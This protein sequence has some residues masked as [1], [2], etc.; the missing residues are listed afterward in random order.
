MARED[1]S[2]SLRR[3]A[4]SGKRPQTTAGAVGSMARLSALAGVAVAAILIPATAFVA[5]TGNNVTNDLV[6]LPLTLEDRPNPQ[7]TRLLA[8]NGEL[9]AYFYKENRQDVPLKEIAPVMQEAMLAIEDARFF[10]HGALDLKGTIRAAVNNASEGQTQGGSTITQ[11][12]VKLTL[13][14]QA[15]TKAERIAATES[16]LARKARELKL[17]I[18]YEREHTKKEILERYLNIA[19]F[20]D[21]AYGIQAAA[22]HY[23]SQSPD[24]LTAT[25]S[26]T[27]AGLVKNPVEF[28]PR[29]YPERALQRR[30]TVL[31]VMQ[32]LGVLTASEVGKESAKPLG[33]KIT[34]YPNGCVT[35]VAA[36]SCDYVRRYLLQE[37]ALGATVAERQTTLERGG[38]TIKTNIDL[39]MQKAANNAV[40]STVNPRDKAIAGMAMVE[41][42]TGK[43]RAVAQSRPMGRD[44]KKGQSFINYTVP[45]AYGD[46]GGFPAGSTFKMFTVAAALKGGIDVGKTY[47]SPRT[48][49]MP[50][51]TYFDCE[52]GGTSVWDPSNSTASGKM[53]MYTGTRLSV[54]TYFAQLER[55]AGL[56]NT[57][58]AAESMGIVV[59]FDPDH[60]DSKGRRDPITNQVPSFTLGVTNVSPL[61]MAAAYAVP[62][63][64]GKYCK[65]MPVNSIVDLKDRVVKEYKPECERVLTKDEAA[66][67]NDILRGVQQPGG[68]GYAN[69]TALRVPSAAKTGTTQENK[70]VWYNGYTPE[71]STA[72]MIAGVTSKGL[73]KSLAGVTIN[74]RFLN[75][76]SVGGSSLAGPMWKK[77]MGIVQDYLEPSNFDVPPKRQPAPPK[78]KDD[79][80][81]GD[82]PQDPEDPDT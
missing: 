26:A 54:N 56:C 12:L 73:P 76:A 10:K 22:F 74:G 41:P 6:N 23:F 57:V 72:A 75:F 47:K 62:A 19:Y 27:L 53:N 77:A 17:A 58:K 8:S 44:R 67:I 59:P 31:A 60:K 82:D 7:T 45:R 1:F 3:L 5:V 20:G 50:A 9:M 61:D 11:Q 52:G 33:L 16:S 42:G 48:I 13:L 66:Q 51:G 38:L 29:V 68:F 32:R 4:Q 37:P 34:K 30:N 25:Q 78:E 80:K 69:G 64:G 49:H 43:V 71:L 15:T 24:K 2:A 18:T 81:K 70:A 21:G 36:F 28:D 63:S 55:D 79:K 65:P 14:S 46:S 35:S 40:K 39:R